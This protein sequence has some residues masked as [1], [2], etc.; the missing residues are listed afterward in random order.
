MCR[1][2]SCWG[3]R[4]GLEKTPVL[5]G[6]SHLRNLRVEQGGGI[7]WGNNVDFALGVALSPL[8]GDT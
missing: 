6:P 1:T 3:G 2:R 8:I 7:G 5:P 4:E